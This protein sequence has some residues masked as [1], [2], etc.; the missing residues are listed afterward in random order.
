M[1]LS[2]IGDA[3]KWCRL[4]HRDISA[5]NI[6]IVR[7]KEIPFGVY[8]IDW[9]LAGDVLEPQLPTL[10]PPPHDPGGIRAITVGHFW[11]FQCYVLKIV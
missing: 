11:M 3:F 10:A 7:N 8:V 4:L 5:G 6:V 1:S 2:A 9:E